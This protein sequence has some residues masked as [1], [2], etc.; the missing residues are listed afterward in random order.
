MGTQGASQCVGCGVVGENEED[1]ED[2]HFYCYA[3]WLIYHA[4]LE[5]IAA[6]LLKFSRN[7]SFRVYLVHPE[8]RSMSAV[9][10]M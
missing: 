10:R 6:R 2:G 5:Q 4:A 8:V 9:F 7:A 1:N 3:F